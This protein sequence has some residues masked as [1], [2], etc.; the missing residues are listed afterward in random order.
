M[1]ASEILKLFFETHPNLDIQ[2][3]FMLEKFHC[4]TFDGDTLKK[5]TLRE[6]AKSNV[7]SCYPIRCTICFCAH[8]TVN[9]VVLTPFSTR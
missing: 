2:T 9:K 8:K 5:E 7:S 4:E 6:G 3:T 1:D